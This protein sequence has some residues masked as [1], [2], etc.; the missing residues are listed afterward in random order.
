MKLREWLAVPYDGPGGTRAAVRLWL[1][2]V[3]DGLADGPPGFA[4]WRWRA[5]LLVRRMSA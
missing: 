2:D 1:R 3:A 5:S 4:R